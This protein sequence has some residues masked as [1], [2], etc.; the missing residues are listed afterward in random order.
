VEP[1]AQDVVVG[2]LGLGNLGGAAARTLRAIGYQILG[3][4]RRGRPVDGVSVYSG[5][6]GLMQVLSSAKIVVSMLPGTAATQNLLNHR[7]L[8]VMQRGSYLINVGRGDTVVDADLIRLLCSGYIAGATLDVFRSEPLDPGDPYW[9]TPNVLVTSHTASAI[10]PATGGQVISRNVLSFH[11][12][13]HVPDIVDL[14]QG[15]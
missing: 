2:I 15:Y 4:S 13:E 11:R 12:G 8:S 5:E 10:E 3:W 7:R 14:E 6:D 1:L 9:A